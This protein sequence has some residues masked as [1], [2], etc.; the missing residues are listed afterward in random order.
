MLTGDI[1]NRIYAIWN[2]LWSGGIA[3]P[4]EQQAAIPSIAKQLPLIQEVQTDQF[5]VEASL[6]SLEQVRGSV[7][8]LV[9]L[10]EKRKQPPI[11]TDF[12]DEIGEGE[13]IEL[14]AFTAGVD[15]ERVRE[16]ALLFLR[17]HDE[18]VA[19]HKLRWNE[20]LTAGDLE[21][22]ET[23]FMSEGTTSEEIEAAR[24]EGGLGLFVRSLVGLDREAAKLAFSQF[25]GR[26]TA[27]QLEFVNLV[28]NHLTSR[29]WMDAAQLY[30]SP[31]VDR[32]PA[33]V[34]GVFD[35]ALASQLVAVLASIKQN[36]APAYALS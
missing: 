4:V 19:I 23:I 12:T 16:K 2:A 11:I 17:K 13:L 29:G 10:I 31:F 22:L 34:N 26:L 5:W 35:D 33:S 20:P 36:A 1:R 21:A 9:S 18:G 28:I 25:A 15:L 24:G 8:G 30:A 27:N 14:P 3:N 32:H 6:D 7:R